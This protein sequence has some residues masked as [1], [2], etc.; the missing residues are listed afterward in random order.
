MRRLGDME[1]QPRFQ[2]CE[3]GAS[4]EVGIY[5]ELHASGA[6]HFVG[7]GKVKGPMLSNSPSATRLHLHASVY[8]LVEEEVMCDHG[9]GAN[10]NGKEHGANGF[11]GNDSQAEQAGIGVT[12]DGASG[13]IRG[14]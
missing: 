4:S 9:A 11:H 14:A 7:R 8:G 1:R 6:E 2:G 5:R 3:L 10:A 12:L 13:G